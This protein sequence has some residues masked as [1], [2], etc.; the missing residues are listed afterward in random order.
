ML[1]AE[2]RFLPLHSELSS[3]PVKPFNLEYL[4]SQRLKTSPSPNG[5]GDKPVTSFAEIYSQRGENRTASCGAADPVRDP[6]PAGDSRAESV[7]VYGR[8]SGGVA[9]RIAANFSQPSGPGR[10]YHSVISQP[11]I[12][13][14]G[15][16]HSNVLPAGGHEQLM[17]QQHAPSSHG[18]TEDD[19]GTEFDGLSTDSSQA[20]L[21]L[22]LLKALLDKRSSEKKHR[23]GSGRRSR[24][25][26]LPRPTD[27]SR[28]DLPHR[29]VLTYMGN[30][31]AFIE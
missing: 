14:A 26:G 28:S 11:R 21:E 6:T 19:T 4:M 7:D 3:S 1:D 13:S 5:T 23:K 22:K 20:S 29:W 17:Q 10:G 15:S 24:D 16:N 12:I 27:A 18:N 2:T 25:Q 31:P 8:P 30:F 9:R